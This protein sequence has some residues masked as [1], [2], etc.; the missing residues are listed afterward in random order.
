MSH[1]ASRERLPVRAE[2]VGAK[3]GGSMGRRCSYEAPLVGKL[4]S[5]QRHERCSD[6][7]DPAIGERFV[8]GLCIAHGT[9]HATVR[10]RHATTG[11]HP[12][13]SRRSHNWRARSRPQPKIGRTPYAPTRRQGRL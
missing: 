10:V 7:L 6:Q 13:R 3:P 1:P 5:V 4:G 2:V 8:L 11:H 9:D 12:R